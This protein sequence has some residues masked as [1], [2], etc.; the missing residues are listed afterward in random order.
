MHK[1]SRIPK[2]DR[3]MNQKI[4]E[5][6]GVK[7]TTFQHTECKQVL[8]YRHLSRMGQETIPQKNLITFAN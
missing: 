2:L 5:E 8:W 7:V 4:R 1:N 6:T 3:K